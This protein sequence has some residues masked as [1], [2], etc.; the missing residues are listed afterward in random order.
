MR[1][2]SIAD[3]KFKLVL[4]SLLFILAGLMAT[5]LFP[6]LAGLYPTFVGAILGAS[7]LY[8]GANVVSKKIDLPLAKIDESELRE[9]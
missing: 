7:G 3:R 2:V 4:I 8:F 5:V 1:K 9:D 6:S